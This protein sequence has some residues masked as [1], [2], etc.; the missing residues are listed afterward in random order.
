MPSASLPKATGNVMGKSK[1]SRQ[2]LQS[3]KYK[4]HFC[5][6][7]L[8]K[9]PLSGL[10]L[11]L[12]VLGVRCWYCPH[13]FEIRIRPCGWLRLVLAPFWAVINMLHRQ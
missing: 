8:L 1:E 4:C 5:R 9:V 3:L 12:A 2:W 13:C 10:W 6:N 11:I 7:V